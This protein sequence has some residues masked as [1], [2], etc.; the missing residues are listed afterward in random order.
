MWPEGSKLRYQNP[1]NSIVENKLFRVAGADVVLAL[2]M[3]LH[4]E[5]KCSGGSAFCFCY[6]LLGGTLIMWG[7]K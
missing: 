3:P 2:Q 5:E 4:C 7:P 6:L 1:G